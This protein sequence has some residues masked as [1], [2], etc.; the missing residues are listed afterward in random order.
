MQNFRIIPC[1]FFRFFFLFVQPTAQTAY[2]RTAYNGSKCVFWCKEVPFGGVVYPEP[3][4]GFQG[5]KNP[6]NF[7]RDRDFPC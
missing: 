7:S 4:L 6:K 1:P 5:R 2:R 3:F